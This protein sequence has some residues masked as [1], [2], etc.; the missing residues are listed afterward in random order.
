VTDHEPR[1]QPCWC[2]ATYCSR[3]VSPGGVLCSAHALKLGQLDRALLR[4][5]EQIDPRGV[6]ERP[7]NLDTVHC[8]ETIAQAVEALAVA[9]HASITNLWRLRAL[10]LRSV[11]ERREGRP[12]P[13]AAMPE[14]GEYRQA[15]L[16]PEPTP[17]RPWGPERRE[18]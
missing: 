1:P 4:A 9:E 6:M 13:L 17:A 10:Q 18:T 5:L 7:C 12:D 3:Q 11:L 15:R 16:I 14:P 2:H 8:L